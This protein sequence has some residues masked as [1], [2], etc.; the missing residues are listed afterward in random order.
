MKGEI[1]RNTRSLKD[2]QVYIEL[3][4]LWNLRGSVDL[5][6]TQ[7]PVMGSQIE[8]QSNRNYQIKCNSTLN[9]LKCFALIDK[10]QT[11]VS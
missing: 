1:V 8:K 3:S 2:S 4:N 6:F 5:F 9:A 11:S 10:V 7:V